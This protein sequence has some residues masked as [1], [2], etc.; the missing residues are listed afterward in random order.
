MSCK[1]RGQPRTIV[2][3]SSS[4]GA[5]LTAFC[6]LAL[7]SS[8]CTDSTPEARAADAAAAPTVIPVVT[9][10]AHIEQLGIEIEAVGT[11]Q[12]NES[13]EVTSKASNTVTAIR[14]Q[15]G[16]EVERGEVLVEMDDAQARASLAEAQRRAREMVVER[17][18]PERAWGDVTEELGGT[19]QVVVAQGSALVLPGPDG[20]EPADDETVGAVLGL[21]AAPDRLEAVKW[22]RQAPRW[23]LGEVM[24]SGQRDDRGPKGA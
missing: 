18:D 7:L 6:V 20:V 16:E 10:A 1:E 5:R 8:G 19:G 12:A 3:L 2:S 13:V 9:Q 11:T 15:E 23:E 17:H 22:A 14:F 4:A 21:G 24:V